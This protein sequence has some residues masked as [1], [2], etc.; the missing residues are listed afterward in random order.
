MTYSIYSTIQEIAHGYEALLLDAYGVFWGGNSIGLFP[1]SKEAMASLIQKGKIVGIL[2]NSSAIAEKEID[3]LK[4]HGLN[5]GEHYHFLLSSGEVAK[6]LFDSAHLPFSTPKKKYVAFGD[7]HPKFPHASTFLET[8]PYSET[9]RIEEADFILITIPH[10]DGE[11]QLDPSLFREA[12]KKFKDSKLP[13][14]CINPDRF[15]HEGNPVKVVVRQ[16]AI[17]ELYEEV[18]GSV[19]YIGKPHTPAYEQAMDCF[20]KF[21]IYDKTRIL[22][23]GDT[24]ETDIRGAKS[25]GMDAALLTETGLMSEETKK[26]GLEAAIK[27]LCQEEFPNHFVKRL[28]AYAF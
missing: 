10:L 21:G 27:R 16:G 20:A 22:M 14:V 12:V 9:T 26:H 5:E 4:S 18:G 13:M 7:K 24:P 8:T 17:A 11:D 19:F 15:A 25:F 23:V 3:K 6:N 1:G 28:G 2:T